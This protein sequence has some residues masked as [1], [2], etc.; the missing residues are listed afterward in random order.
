MPTTDA[1]VIVYRENNPDDIA[2]CTINIHNMCILNNMERDLQVYIYDLC[3]VKKTKKTKETYKSPVYGL[4]YFIENLAYQNLSKKDIYL[5]VDT[6]NSS[7]NKLIEIYK[8]YGFILKETDCIPIV[9]RIV[10]YKKITQSVIFNSSLDLFYF[11][12]SLT[13]NFNCSRSFSSDSI[14]DLTGLYGPNLL[15]LRLFTKDTFDFIGISVY[16]IGTIVRVLFR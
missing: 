15:D 14:L 10:M 5:M 2:S 6:S 8:K 12:E 7:K 16:S 13:C 3:R 1:Y 4:F 9:N 11:F